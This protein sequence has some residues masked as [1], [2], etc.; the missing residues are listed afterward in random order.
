MIAEKDFSR[1]NGSWVEMSIYFAHWSQKM[2]LQTEGL[3]H[4]CDFSITRPTFHIKWSNLRA[5]CEQ[6]KI[7]FSL[8]GTARAAC[9]FLSV[10]E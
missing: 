4:T 10:T 2:E 8:N 7:L 1:K 5:T 6:L 3:F 9:A